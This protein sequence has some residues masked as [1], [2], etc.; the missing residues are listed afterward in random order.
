MP[1]PRC[2]CGHPLSLHIHQPSPLHPGDKPKQ[3]FCRSRQACTCANF[4]EKIQES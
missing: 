4:R 1:V 3:G 2:V